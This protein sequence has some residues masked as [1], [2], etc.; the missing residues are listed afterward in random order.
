MRSQALLDARNGNNS[1]GRDLAYS[2][3][4]AVSISWNQIVS[5]FKSHFKKC[6][7]G[8]ENPAC[9]AT[10]YFEEMSLADNSQPF[11][12]S[13]I[14][15]YKI[16][17]SHPHFLKWFGRRGI[18]IAHVLQV[19]DQEF[20]IEHHLFGITG[21]QLV[22]VGDFMQWRQRAAEW[23]TRYQ[24]IRVQ[25]NHLQQTEVWN[26]IRKYSLHLVIRK[27]MTYFR[28]LFNQCFFSFSISFIFVKICQ[29]QNVGCCYEWL[30]TSDWRVDIR[31]TLT[32]FHSLQIY[33]VPR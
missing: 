26:K 8:Y 3:S 17:W 12:L 25:R 20:F 22:N 5:I 16:D 7:R 14:S 1:W 4:N 29:R 33:Y 15:W 2:F 9:F 10:I 6:Y 28:N 11:L 18:A 21:R 32:N 13:R 31:E 19:V 30:L 23:R 24:Q 27:R